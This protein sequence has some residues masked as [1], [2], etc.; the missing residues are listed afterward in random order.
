MAPY[1]LGLAE[2]GFAIH[3]LSAEK[4]KQKQLIREYQRQFEAAGVKW[5]W[6]NY[7]N[8]PPLAGQIFTQWRLMSVARKIISDNNID[9]VHCRSF[10]AAFIAWKLQKKNRLRYIYDFRDFYTDGN[11]Q[12]SRGI[13]R[14]IFRWLRTLDQ[15]LVRNASWIVCLTNRA[16]ALL[17]DRFLTDLPDM[18]DR[19]SVIPCCADFN[20]FDPSKISATDRSFARDRA[21]LPPEAVTLVYLGSLGPDYLLSEMISL[22][23]QLIYIKPNAYFLFVSNNGQKLVNEECARQGVPF[24][25]IRFVTADRNEV[26]AFI[27]IGDLSVVFIRADLSKAG[28]SPTKLAELFAMG[29]PVI[30]NSGVG[31]LDDLI[32]PALNGSVLVREFTDEALVVAIN[33]VINEQ[34]DLGMIRQNSFIFDLT[35]G[36]EAYAQIYDR[37]LREI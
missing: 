14:L 26:P 27:S 24:S 10:P 1:V 11:F 22:F 20:H 8:S 29:I 34:L 35:A 37:L 4:P 2:K 32:D 33:T 18:R 15:H 13:K 31:D 19:F 30:A 21:G 7:R 12:T 23:K 25:R 36:I 6:I 9:L 3:V 16:V 28:C 5:T 17:S